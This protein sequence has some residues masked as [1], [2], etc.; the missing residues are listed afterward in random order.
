MEL[1]EVKEKGYIYAK[2]DLAKLAHIYESKISQETKNANIN[3]NDTYFITYKSKKYYNK[4]ALQKLKEYENLKQKV[5]DINQNVLYEQ[6]KTLGDKSTLT[7]NQGNI[8]WKVKNY[9]YSLYL[10]VT[11][12]IRIECYI[13]PEYGKLELKYTFVNFDEIKDTLQINDLNKYK[14]IVN[15]FYNTIVRTIYLTSI[16]PENTWNGECDINGCL[17][18]N[19]FAT[20]ITYNEL[21][22]NKGGYW[23]VGLKL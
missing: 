1:N 21:I 19:L 7:N 20:P 12:N 11:E 9:P 17:S 15:Y 3:I 5:K 2:T 16:I 4:G 18:N 22:E 13:L 8:V 23:S 10:R 6:F 14:K